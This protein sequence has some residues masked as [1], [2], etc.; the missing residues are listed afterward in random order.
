LGGLV[1][2]GLD[3]F[4]RR[5]LIFNELAFACW[6][7]RCPNLVTEVTALTLGVLVCAARVHAGVKLAS[8]LDVGKL[9]TFGL[10]VGTIAAHRHIRVLE[11]AVWVSAVREESAHLFGLVGGLDGGRWVATSAFAVLAS[12]TV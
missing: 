6:S 9:A 7:R 2:L 8:N 5:V 1:C 3:Q 11:V 10:A 12:G 4:L